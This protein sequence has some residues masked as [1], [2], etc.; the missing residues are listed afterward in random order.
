M[1]N[2]FVAMFFVMVGLAGMVG[3][4]LVLGG[5]LVGLP[6]A[7]PCLWAAVW[8]FGNRYVGTNGNR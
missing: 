1:T 3:V 2:W 7:V 8:F 5:E 6:I 4:V